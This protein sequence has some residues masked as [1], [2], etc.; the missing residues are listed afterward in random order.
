MTSVLITL[1]IVMA[2][3]VL[4]PLITQAIPGKPI[5]Q[6]VLLLVGGALLGPYMAGVVKLS[7]PMSLLSNL[8]LAFL[9][10]LAGYEIRFC[11]RSS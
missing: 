5:S 7:L 4:C 6:T 8:G 11:R 10:L 9:F 1:T 2:V 3:A